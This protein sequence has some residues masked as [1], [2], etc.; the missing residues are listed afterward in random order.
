MSVRRARQEHLRYHQG[1][2]LFV[3]RALLESPVLQGRRLALFVLQGNM[4]IRL[5]ARCA[6]I[7]HEEGI[8]P[9][10]ETPHCP[11]AWHVLQADI[12]FKDHRRA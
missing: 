7:A 10:Q 4:E 1:L 5:E 11:I 12:L 8:L 3:M 9:R 6:L 2:F